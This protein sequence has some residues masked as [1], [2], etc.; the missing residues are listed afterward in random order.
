MKKEIHDFY[1]PYQ[2]HN[3][4]DGHPIVFLKGHY[5]AYDMESE[6]LIEIVNNKITELN[7]EL[8]K[9]NALKTAMG[10]EDA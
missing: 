1:G 5:T 2:I 8:L 6:K 10:K 9:W 7:T 4:H 3:T